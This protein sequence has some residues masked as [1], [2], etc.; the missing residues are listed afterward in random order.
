[1]LTG[2]LST[3]FTEEVVSAGIMNEKEETEV[4]RSFTNPVLGKV[5]NIHDVHAYGGDEAEL[6]FGEKPIRR[7]M[8]TSVTLDGIMP[9]L[10]EVPLVVVMHVCEE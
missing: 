10:G 5:E 2:R 7:D 1:M 6:F 9:D 4:G 3:L 8:A